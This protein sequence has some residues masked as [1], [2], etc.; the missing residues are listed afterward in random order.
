ML[1]ARNQLTVGCNWF[2]LYELIRT[3]FEE[4]WIVIVAMSNLFFYKHSSNEVIKYLNNW[5]RKSLWDYVRR[6]DYESYIFTGPSPRDTTLPIIFSQSQLYT[7]KH[8]SLCIIKRRL[9]HQC[10]CSYDFFPFF[11]RSSIE[12]KNMFQSILHFHKIYP[13]YWRD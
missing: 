1:F 2:L 6:K 9:L 8:Y 11:F 4:K 3:N 13:G 10:C 5:E 12:V 7:C